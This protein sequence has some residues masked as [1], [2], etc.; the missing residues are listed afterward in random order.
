MPDFLIVGGQRCGTTS[1]YRYLLEHPRIMPPSTKEL[2]FF[3][4][5]IDGGELLYRSYF[6]L[7]VSRY[8]R[9]A[10]PLTRAL[11]FEA[12]PYYM[13]HPLAPRRIASM[14]PRIKLIALLRNPVHRAYSHYHLEVRLGAENLSFEEAIEE[15]P[16]R[17]DGEE[18][19]MLED[20]TYR[21]FNHQHFSYVTR[22]KYADQIRALL[23]LFGRDRLLVIRSEDF[24]EDPGTTLDRVGAFLQIGPWRPRRVDRFHRAQYDTMSLSTYERL[25]TTYRPHNQRLRDVLNQTFAWKRSGD[26]TLARGVE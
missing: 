15:E 7:E 9:R 24:F 18:E 13:F 4:F 6:P 11:A 19:R 21:S 25:E 22:G 5:G 8:V 23:D 26:N 3:D 14:L 12:S 20:P 16:D 2:H 1:L 10:A 17:L